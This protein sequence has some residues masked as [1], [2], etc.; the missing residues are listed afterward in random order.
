M[1]LCPEGKLLI[2]FPQ[3]ST[4]LTFVGEFSAITAPRSIV[5]IHSELYITNLRDLWF[6]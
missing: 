4:R 2:E 1:K 5:V 3:F 6:G